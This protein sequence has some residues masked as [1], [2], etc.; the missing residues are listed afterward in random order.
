MVPWRLDAPE[1]GYATVVRQELVSGW[2]STLLQ[3]KGTGIEV[4]VCRG[5][6]Q[7]RDST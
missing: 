1:K 6:T 7:K 3:A 2:V 5:E 4:G